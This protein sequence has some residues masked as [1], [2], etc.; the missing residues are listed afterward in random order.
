MLWKKPKLVFLIIL[1]NSSIIGVIFPD[2]DYYYI[3]TTFFKE[4]IATDQS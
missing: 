3:K 1:F 4:F 2:F